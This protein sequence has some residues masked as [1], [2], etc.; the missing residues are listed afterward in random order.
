MSRDI[1]V[2]HQKLSAYLPEGKRITGLQP[3]TAGHSNETYIAEGLNAILRLP[4][5]T[6][7]LLQAHDIVTQARIYREVGQFDSG[8]PVPAI[9]HICED[10]DVLGDPFFM[11]EM[12]AG[13]SLHD[14]IQPQWFTSL[15][16]DKRGDLCR[17]WVE[18][19]GSIAR[20]PPLETLGEPVT[21]ADELRRWQNICHHN[22]CPRLVALI[23]R[24]LE[25]PAPRSGPVS[26]AH[27]DCKITNM[28][29]RDQR[30][31]AVLDWELGYNGEPLSDLGYMLYAFESDFHGPTRTI[32]PS[33]MWT[34]EQVIPAWE[35]AS[36][37]SASGL[38]WYEAAE[39]A[40]LGGIYA[41]AKQ[42][43]NTGD[44][45]DDR[46][47]QFIAKLD[48]SIEIISAMLPLVA[49]TCG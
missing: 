26:P 35:R 3:L 32:S 39:V 15:A 22:D 45:A 46:M 28:M 23:D 13:E 11:M 18:A 7:P 14:Y 40:K 30:L 42:L 8:P 41:K 21:P 9:L 19:I 29:F 5:S 33:G 43:Y 16:G 6:P 1:E 37:R 49:K 25:I 2:L 48:E 12:I 24:L 27:G 34:R 36:G 31:A 47:L 44:S 17:H 10:P 20:L 38:I 4:P